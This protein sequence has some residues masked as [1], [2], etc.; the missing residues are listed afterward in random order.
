[1]HIIILG[2]GVIGTATAF[3]LAE[4]GHQVTVIER[5]ARPG[6]G[7]SRANGAILHP[8]S[9]GPWS[10]PGTPRKILGWMGDPKAPFLLRPAALP[11]MWRW[12]IDFLRNTTPQRHAANE[13]SNQ[14]LAIETLQALE[15]IRARTGITWHR[16]PEGVLQLIGSAA[17]FEAAKVRA[18]KLN[19]AGLD[20][21]LLDQQQVAAID[22]KL[23]RIGN[24]IAG[25]LHVRQDE[26]SNAREFCVKLA[27]WSEAEQAVRFR[28]ATMADRLLVSAGRVEGVRAGGESI[29]ADAVVV[30]MGPQSAPFLRAH[31]VRVPIYPVKGVSITWPREAWPDAPDVALLDDTRHFA[32][33]PL[34]GFVRIVGS[35]EIT[36]FDATPDPLRI[37]AITDRVAELFPDLPQNDPRG[38]M[39]AGLRPMTPS[40]TPIIGAAPGIAGLWLNTGHGHTGWTQSAGSARRLAALIGRA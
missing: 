14:T 25:A 6:E 11:H 3:M 36:G 37:R 8:S 16:R 18:A 20:A 13:A 23:A 31:G 40:G 12:G 15:A 4:A 1:M 21:R 24:R 17:G 9:V 38:E 27:A 29:A 35:A 10:S 34:D 19:A 26:V 22:P 32:F 39:W 33:V 2:A 7:T 30:A 5:A 28:F